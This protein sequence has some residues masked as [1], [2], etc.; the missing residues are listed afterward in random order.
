ML[1]TTAVV[2]SCCGATT[3]SSS[4]SNLDA[5]IQL[6]AASPELTVI[7]G[8]SA[9][10]MVGVNGTNYNG[11]VDLAVTGP[12]AGITASFS[13]AAVSGAILSKLTVSAA[14]TASPGTDTLKLIATGVGAGSSLHDSLSLVVVVSLPRVTVAKAG[15]GVGTVTSNPAAIS[16]G[17]TCGAGFALGT[18]VTLTA[19]APAGNVFA[20]WSG[21]CS[22]TDASCT[23]TVS[24]PQ[25]AVTA[26]FNSTAPG[27]SM[28]LS[29]T[30]VSLQQ[31]AAGSA[32][33]TLTRNNGFSGAVALAASGMP[34]GLAVT[35]NPSSV[36]G[37]TSTLNISAALTVPVGNYP[38]TIT[39]IGSG[40]PNQ[41]ATLA[42]QVTSAPGGSGDITY[43]FAACD[44]SQVP[45]WFA[46]QSGTGAWTQ[47][48]QGAGNTF[49]FTPGA[50]GGVAYVTQ[51]ANAYAT[52]ITYGSAS[53]L[54]AIATG[55]GPCGSIPQVGTKRLT[56]L[57]TR[58]I[59]LTGPARV[60]IGAAE[61]T[62]SAASGGGY[63]LNT[64]P[65]GLR[66]LVASSSILDADNTTLNMR[67]VIR[68]GIDYPNN[69]AI[70]NVDYFGPESFIANYRQD[71]LFNLGTDASA[72]TT[73]LLTA[74][75]T[76]QPFYSGI[77]GSRNGTNLVP[78][79]A[80][81]DS[82]LQPGDFHITRVVAS[83]QGGNGAT[84]RFVFLM[85]H[86][87]TKQS[88]TFGPVP[89]IPTVTS[90]GSAPYL[91]VRAQ[92]ARQA[93]YGSAAKADFQQGSNDISV[94]ITALYAS[95]AP[96]NWTID[97]PDLT[98]AGYNASWGLKSGTPLDWSILAV[99]GN[100]LAFSGG[101][102]VDGAQMV[103]GVTSSSSSVTFSRRVPLAPWRP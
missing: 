98:G 16:C 71:T 75:G 24:G 14:S 55:P 5:R 99:G 77:G 79:F 53:E 48:A 25:Q 46:V 96:A 92:W 2:C 58:E 38:I 59:S 73:S 17:S 37:T 70:P 88:L 101:P 76:S 28:A 36:T 11:E 68:R 35:A 9:S 19:T 67:L 30:A 3:D 42:V 31:G 56:G 40:V 83:P 51:T 29:P 22:G 34:T 78:V 57:G 32:T 93:A 43:S 64:V 90:L 66:D 89:T 13:P 45:I 60:T 20:G 33:A 95:G 91:R 72:V 84:A 54:M 80:L 81:S 1:L 6:V 100:F 82:A 7:E 103:G 41:V 86:S 15:T 74:N 23:I 27:F 39:A 52:T 65:A 18:N 63:T 44:P 87:L 10:T 102:L 47:I 97:I 26:T 8:S 94:A 61:S 69:S 21:A 85:Q 62:F 50:T 4:G 12:P 49:T